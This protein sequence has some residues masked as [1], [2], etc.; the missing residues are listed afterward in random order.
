MVNLEGL[1][2]VEAAMEKIE[3]GIVS[4]GMLK[5][6]KHPELK[7]AADSAVAA[8]RRRSNFVRLELSEI[9]AELI[10]RETAGAVKRQVLLLLGIPQLSLFYA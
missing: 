9:P 5:L 7:Q 8:I 1:E 2:A 4:T 3:A 10:A 6:G